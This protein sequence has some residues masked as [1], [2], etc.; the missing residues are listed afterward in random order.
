MPVEHE[1]D[2][3]GGRFNQSIEGDAADV[4]NLAVYANE[5]LG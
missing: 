2:V 5:L 4:I 1:I 3:L